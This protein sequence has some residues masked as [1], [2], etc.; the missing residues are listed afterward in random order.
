[1]KALNY[2][3]SLPKYGKIIQLLYYMTL[4]NWEKHAKRL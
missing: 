3:P 2:L 4:H 1:M